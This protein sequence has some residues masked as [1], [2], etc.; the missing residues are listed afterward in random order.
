MRTYYKP[1]LAQHAEKPFNYEDWIFEVKWDGIRAISYVDGGLG[2]KS[3]NDKELK[4]NFPELEE[5]KKLT[6]NTVIDGEII[7]IKAGKADFQALAERSK[8]TSAENIKYLSRESPVNYVAFDILEKDGNSLLQLPLKE[9]KRLLKEYVREGSY[10]VLSA[11]VETDGEAYYKAA[12]AKSME[13]IMAKKKD[14]QYEPGA[15]SANWLKI[16]PI[17]A[18]DCVIFGYTIGKGTRRLTFGALI[19][20]LFGEKEPIYVGKVG[21]GFD[22]ENLGLILK[23]FEPLQVKD[24]TLEGVDAPEEIVWLKPETVCEV[25]YQNVTR[26]G[27]LRMPRF[28]GIRN[29]KLPSECTLDQIAQGRL[30]PYASRRDF[31][32]TPEPSGAAASE[33]KGSAFVVQEHHAR[34]L[35]Y[36]LRLEKGGVLKSWAVPKGIPEQSSEKR[37]AVE[38]EDHPLEYRSFEGTIPEGQYGAGTV[39]IF[40]Q[41]MYETKLWNENMI[42]VTLHGQRLRGRYVLARFKKAGDKQWLLMKAKEAE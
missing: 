16:K 19:L 8:T 3:R 25:A 23:M 15:R 14:S 7:V 17:L 4:P 9:R 26:E 31:S 32:V 41:G 28:L 10:V 20:G 12:L 1:M 29:D 42:E 13:G 27:R 37:L 18:C 36:D 5:L 35:H 33:E 30:E 40:D 11:F 22:Q 38:T 2:I 21:T 39:K 6:E 34:R 24:K